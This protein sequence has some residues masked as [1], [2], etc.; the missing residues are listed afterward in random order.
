MQK[1]DFSQFF[2]L[3]KKWKLCKKCF[4]L[5]YAK[6][7][8]IMQPACFPPLPKIRL[9]PS[10]YDGWASRLAPD[11]TRGWKGGKWEGGQ[12]NTPQHWTPVSFVRARKIGHRV[13]L[14]L[15]L[16]ENAFLLP[17]SKHNNVPSSHT[18]GF[19]GVGGGIIFLKKKLEN[20][21]QNCVCSFFF[22]WERLQKD[23]KKCIFLHFFCIN[24]KIFSTCCL[25]VQPRMISLL[26]SKRYCGGRQWQFVRVAARAWTRESTE[27]SG[28]KSLRVSGADGGD[29]MSILRDRCLPWPNKFR[30]T[31]KM[32]KMPLI[33]VCGPTLAPSLRP[34]ETPESLKKIPCLQPQVTASQKQPKRKVNTLWAI[35]FQ[36]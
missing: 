11:A 33:L 10:S 21:E 24:R 32:V 26:L 13:A 20:T 30:A 19:L 12:L 28:S 14:D 9:W 18:E 27:F 5:D 34:L 1:W 6:E 8:Q 31:Y 16:S 4:F 7:M 36:P 35:K 25:N 17:L 29:Q 3:C 15:R 2:P 23:A 22:I